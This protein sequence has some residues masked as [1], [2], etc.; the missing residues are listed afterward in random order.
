MNRLLAFAIAMAAL[1]CYSLPAR[2]ADQPFTFDSTF[3][4]LPKDVVPLDYDIALIPNIVMRTTAGTESVRLRVRSATSKIVVNTLEMTISSARLGSVPAATISE[5]TTLQQTTLTFAKPF[6]PG[7]YT[8]ALAFA[9]KIGTAAQ[10]LFLQEYQTASGGHEA[11]LAT[12]LESTDAR[13]VFPS[14]DEPAFRATYRLT[15]TVPQ[16]FTAVSNMPVATT[17]PKG[18]L[19]TVTFERTP[20]MST[21]LV[22]FCAGKFKSISDS[23]DGIKVSLYAPSDRIQNGQYALA[24]ATE[25]LAY[26]DKYYD[27]KF[28]LPKLDLIDVPGGFPGAMENWGG[29]VFTES[30]L[31]FDPKTEPEANKQDIFQTV[32]HEMSHQWTGD[33]VTM[34]WWSRIWLNESFAHWMQI[35]ATDHFNPS[36]HLYDS[37]GDNVALAM[38]SDQRTTAHPTVVPVEDET[39][40][41]GAF[42]DV[43]Y[44][45]GGSVIRMF[46]HYL[47]PDTFR[48]GVRAY[49]KAHAYSNA[50]AAD[51][52]AGLSSAA[53]KDVGALV[54]PWIEGAGVPLVSAEATCANGKRTLALSQQRFLIERGQSS[55]RLWPI[56]VGIDVAGTVGYVLLNGKTA[57]VDAGTCDQPYNLDGDSL[58][59]YRVKLDD[60]SEDA[61]L[62]RFPQLSVAERARF[63]D[64]TYALLLAG[65][66]SPA[67]LVATL[68][69]VSPGDPLAVWSAVT[70]ATSDLS[71][72]EVGRPG[73]PAFEAYI[74]RLLDPV[75]AHVGWDAQPMD[76]PQ[77]PV[78]RG[79]LVQRLGFAGDKP[80]IAEAQRRFALFLTNPASL[81]PEL[82]GPVCTVAGTYA[83]DATWA[84]L[85]GLFIG[86][87][88]RAVAFQYGTAL[89]TARDPALAQKNLAMTTNGDI[90]AEDGVVAPYYDVLNVA[91][92]GRH[93]DIAWQFFEGNQDKLATYLTSFEKPAVISAIA[94]L[95]WNAA[96]TSELDALIDG[97]DAP[98]DA[99][100]RA[101][102]VVDLKIAQRDRL[103][104]GVDAAISSGS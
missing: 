65:E 19:K 8:L 60:A 18:T 16:D 85:R 33:L 40:V 93:P 13:R 96:P 90:T 68:G 76:D 47:G 51:L 78:L 2:A 24:S 104:P 21:Y 67:R 63:V 3:G 99:K 38:T 70:R 95:F 88:D 22:V 12:Q 39:Q 55:D 42:D 64:D 28:P 92:G 36:W 32:A 23:V 35:K 77:T 58:G 59:Y 101:K 74:V 9:G 87:K 100:A 57:T 14:W 49:I 11:M 27:Y 83:D 86:T 45:R 82:Q 75:L 20:K 72:L 43:T 41:A 62:A 98:P 80:V 69:K 84:A 73:Q 54:Y 66:A 4:R 25:L 102:H 89:W 5:N 44:E 10:G 56:P 97:S 61:Q 53:H 79:T 48:D 52:F 81:S 1:A 6:A 94:P 29:I 17:V 15:V 26:Y 30:L 103:L 50:T 71:N 31:L 7:T 37:E 46:E 91:L 34:D